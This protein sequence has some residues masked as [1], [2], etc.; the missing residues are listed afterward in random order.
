MQPSSNDALTSA[1]LDIFSLFSFFFRLYLAR[2]AI[3]DI[4]VLV[5]LGD[6]WKWRPESC[7][8]N[9]DVELSRG[10]KERQAHRVVAM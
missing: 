1:E 10:S 3:T 6:W 8:A 7:H 5:K 4:Y 9:K 2:N